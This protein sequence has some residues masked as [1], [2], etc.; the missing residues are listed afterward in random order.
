MYL[1]LTQ[2]TPETLLDRV[3]NLETLE[4]AAR[5]AGINGTHFYA[6]G[7]VPPT[8]A[9]GGT[10]T[11]GIANAIWVSEVRVFGNAFLTGVSVLLGGT[12]GSDHI[13]AILY[14][15]AGNVLAKSASTTVVGTL[16]TFQRL[17]FATP[18]PAAP[19]LYY[20]GVTTDGTT[21]YIRT[22]AAGDHNTGEITGQTFGTPTA[23]TPPTTF[24]AATGPVALL[25]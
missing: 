20:I 17:A 22:Q 10:N 13:Q 1:Q 4:V 24:T 6:G 25:Y 18:Y 21:A 9:T 7:Y 16:N 23:I 12:G 3:N 19:G 11:Q 2:P 5:A 8:L 15:S 14:D